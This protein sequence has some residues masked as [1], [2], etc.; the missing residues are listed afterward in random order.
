MH[1][2]LSVTLYLFYNAGLLSIA[3]DKAEITVGFMD[4][5]TLS[6]RTKTFQEAIDKIL[7]TLNRVGGTHK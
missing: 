2:P 7:D 5:V 3:K 4:N 6:T 1:C